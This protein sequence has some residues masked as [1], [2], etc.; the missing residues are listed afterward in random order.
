L[1]RHSRAAPLPRERPGHCRLAPPPSDISTSSGSDRAGRPARGASAPVPRSGALAG[2]P[3][4]FRLAHVCH[5][6]VPYGSRRSRWGDDSRKC[7][8]GI[9]L[10]PGANGC[11]TPCSAKRTMAG[12]A[13]RSGRRVRGAWASIPPQ[14][15]CNGD[16]V[17]GAGRRQ[18]F[19]AR[20]EP[21]LDRRWNARATSGRPRSAAEHVSRTSPRPKPLQI[22]RS[23]AL[24]R[25]CGSPAGRAPSE[26]SYCCPR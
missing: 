13:R 7:A 26:R 14:V 19:R 8:G 10:A 11:G 24:A 16:A 12:P 9:P 15:R 25:E 1:P 18:S 5:T 17:A 20:R 2:R 23:D 4:P 21:L 3:W 22:G 6:G